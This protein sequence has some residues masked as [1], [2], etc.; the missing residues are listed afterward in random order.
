MQ[1][2][3]VALVLLAGRNAS[4][5]DCAVGTPMQQSFASGA[6]WEMCVLVD[7]RHGLEIRDI[8]YRAPNDTLRSVL[9]SIH[10][11]ETLMHYHEDTASQTLLSGYGFGGE[12][13]ATQT[14]ATCDGDAIILNGAEV[15]QVCSE[16]QTAGILVKYAVQQAIH[17]DRWILST[18]SNVRTLSF[19]TSVSFYEDG[20]ITPGNELSGR[21]FRFTNAAEF[22]N[23]VDDSGRYASRATL[24]YTWRMDFALNTEALDDIVEEHNH[25]IS[26]EEAATRPLEITRIETESFRN[27]NRTSFRGWRVRDDDGSGYYLDPQTSGYEYTSRVFDWAQHD[28]AITVR[29]NCEQHAVNNLGNADTDCGSSLDEFVNDQSLLSESPIL[30]FSLTNLLTPNAEDFPAIS[31]VP[32][33]FELVPFDWT[34]SSP[35][36]QT[37]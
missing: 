8:A 3:M 1:L 12:S 30:W 26:S 28:L 10:L 9:R 19:N 35:F 14:A 15:P 27:V 31:T 17:T 21:V 23:R 33:T 6:S 29:N 4:A 22:G 36:G 5:A 37:Q 32:A 16:L 11:A 20:R 13:I 34:S 24:L 18:A 2:A 7:D 25:S